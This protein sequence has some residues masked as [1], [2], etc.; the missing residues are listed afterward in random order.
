MSETV[1]YNATITF[2][3]TSADA[4][5]E[6]LTENFWMDEVEPGADLV[7]AI[8]ENLAERFDSVEDPEIEHNADGTVTIRFTGQRSASEAGDAFSYLEEGGATGTVHY[9]GEDGIPGSW[10]FPSGS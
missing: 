7:T 5:A 3:A 1:D 6:L 4:I 9:V 10:T 8:A 2:P